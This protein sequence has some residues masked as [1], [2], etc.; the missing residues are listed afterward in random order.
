MT[1]QDRIHVRRGSTADSAF[2]AQNDRLLVQRGSPGCNPAFWS[3]R[4]ALGLATLL[5]AE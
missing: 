4:E 3:S 5:R 2:A 1:A